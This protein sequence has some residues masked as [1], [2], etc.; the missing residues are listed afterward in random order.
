MSGTAW[1]QKGGEGLSALKATPTRSGTGLESGTWQ[2]LLSMELRS[3]SLR[4]HRI[5]LEVEEKMLN[6]ESFAFIEHPVKDEIV[7]VS[8]SITVSF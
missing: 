2:S 3:T 5:I 4:Y 8:G 1:S 6:N 7:V